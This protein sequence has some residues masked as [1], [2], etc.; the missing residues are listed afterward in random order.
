MLNKILK[1]GDSAAVTI[2]KQTLKELGVAIG[3]KVVVTFLPEA[4]EITI[5]PLK[6]K[7][8]IVSDRF[9]RLT[10]SFI[11]HYKPALLELAGK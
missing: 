9:L 3:D 2:P 5:K 1:V 4:G 8:A 10:S 7:R 6:K 11:N